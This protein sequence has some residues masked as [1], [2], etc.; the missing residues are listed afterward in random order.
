MTDKQIKDQ[1]I[2]ELNLIRRDYSTIESDESP[3]ALVK[4]VEKRFNKLF[5]KSNAVKLLVEPEHGYIIDANGKACE[6]YGHT[7]HEIR[8]RK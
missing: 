7:L 2:H 3:S 1:S 4:D 6:F 5:S 8:Q